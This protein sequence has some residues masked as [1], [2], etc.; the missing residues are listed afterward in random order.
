MNRSPNVTD[1]KVFKSLIVQ[2]IPHEKVPF[3]YPG[4]FIVVVGICHG[5]LDETAGWA[6]DA[7]L[8]P[9]FPIEVAEPMAVG[10]PNTKNI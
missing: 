8:T 1:E 7:P 10:V 3:V 9:L 6:F 4:S 5:L 2:S